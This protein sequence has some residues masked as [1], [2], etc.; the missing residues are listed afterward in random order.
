MSTHSV[1][2][3]SGSEDDAHCGSAGNVQFQRKFSVT[4]SPMCSKTCQ[5]LPQDL[6]KQRLLP[7]ACFELRFL[8]FIQATSSRGLFFQWIFFLLAIV[9]KVPGDLQ[10][11]SL[12]AVWL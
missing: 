10:A 12:W 3:G 1:S 7:V 5:L 8:F 2:S 4:D 6:S 11:Q 9:P